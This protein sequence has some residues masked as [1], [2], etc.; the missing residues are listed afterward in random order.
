MGLVCQP[1]EDSEESTIVPV[2]NDESLHILGCFVF[3][4]SKGD[5]GWNVDSR[6]ECLVTDIV[7]WV[8]RSTTIVQFGTDMSDPQTFRNHRTP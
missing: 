4:A 5:D 8:C 7:G 2:A 1:I 6:R 3:V